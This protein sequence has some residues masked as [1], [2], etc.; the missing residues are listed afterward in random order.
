LALNHHRICTV[1]D[2]GEEDVLVLQQ[3]NRALADAVLS[4][5]AVGLRDLR[6]GIW[7]CCCLEP[8]YL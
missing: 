6:Q 1:H 5:D 4:A 3:S 2:F 7:S 8:Q